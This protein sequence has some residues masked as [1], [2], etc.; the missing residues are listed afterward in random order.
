[1]ALPQL[2]LLGPVECSFADGRLLVLANR[3][4]WALLAYLALH[5]GEILGRESLAALLWGDRADQQARRSLRQAL[6]EIRV[7]L[8][9]CAS[10]ALIVTRDRV[11]LRLDDVDAL[12]FARLAAGSGLEDLSEAARLYRGPLLDGVETGETAFDAWLVFERARFQETERRAF[13]AL[14]NAQL[15]RG[16]AEAALVTAR[17]LIV[18]D[19]LN[20]AGHRLVMRALAACGRRNEA[21]TH[22]GA[23]ERL[24]R[25]ELAVA[26]TA[27]T[28][29]V[30]DGLRNGGTVVDSGSASSRRDDASPPN[31]KLGIAVLPFDNLS[32]D[33]QLELFA[34]GIT[35]DL[36]SYLSRVPALS[37]IARSSA[38]TFKGR[39]T[40]VRDV[41]SALGVRY[42]LEGSVQGAGRRL[43]VAA[44][45]IDGATGNCVW[46][47]RY[48]RAVDAL[49]AV[50]DDI[51]K[52]VVVE[53]EVTLT[54]GE[55]ARIASR[56][57]ENLDAWLLSVRAC[58]EL[59]KWSREGHLRARHLY[60]AALEAD[61]DWG[62][63][64][65][66]IAMTYRESSLRG[67]G[68]SREEDFARGLAL[69]EQAV[70]MPPVDP[71]AFSQLGCFYILMGR[72][73]EGVSLSEK[74][75]GLSPSDGRV[76][77]SAAMN[78]IRAGRFERALSLHARMRKTNPLPSRPDLANEGF[79]LHMLG[80]HDQ[81][82]GVL[83]D[84]VGRFGFVVARVRL[85]AVE[86][87][88]GRLDEA[89]AEIARVLE[90]DPDAT[91]EEYAGNVTF[92][93]PARYAWYAGLLRSA[94][95]SDR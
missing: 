65:V 22:Y 2:R 71:L 48:D 88:R 75:L 7:A 33:P 60:S 67:W 32:G 73:D 4:S 49:F 79:A 13:E 95:L 50:Q 93:D 89:R 94:G 11:G 90:T 1:M 21:L 41:A 26:P 44:Q 40:D 54:V 6:H 28:K 38:E 34:A 20:E 82:A 78:L 25:E 15:E 81:A 86:A 58:S 83:S 47:D 19:S 39:K 74:A 87:D 9:E 53:M 45:L 31:D 92:T 42:V 55:Q 16:L 56:G 10:G 80:R 62:V 77:G 14:A 63:P 69:A 84:C 35:D 72:V 43:R 70:D 24:L 12:R 5:P 68:V 66:G 59:M 37:V 91:V 23:V 8:G 18:D 29:A 17:R 52:R 64:V 57:T 3:K 30:R 85:A 76:L 27:E 61:P 36:I 46:A 51:V